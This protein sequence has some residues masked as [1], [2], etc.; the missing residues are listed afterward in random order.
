[1]AARA[2]PSSRTRRDVDP[3]PVE[4]L[5]HHLGERR[6]AE[7]AVEVAEGEQV[8]ELGPV[9]VSP[10]RQLEPLAPRE[11]GEQVAVGGLGDVEH[12]VGLDHVLPGGRESERGAGPGPDLGGRL[13]RSGC[14]AGRLGD[15][16]PQR[17]APLP[18]ALVQERQRRRR[19]CPI[20]PSGPVTGR[21][22][23]GGAPGLLLR[24]RPPARRR[25][26]RRARP[27]S[28][29]ARLP[30][31][32]DGLPV[33]R[34]GPWASKMAPSAGSAIEAGHVAEPLL[35]ERAGE[36]VHAFPNLLELLV[37]HG[38]HHRRLDTLRCG[39]T[40][41][42]SMPIYEYDCPKCGRFDVAPEDVGA[43]R[44]AGTTPAARR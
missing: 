13:P 23:V 21:G 44:S 5:E 16:A 27:A 36:R 19:R 34:R 32:G 8:E 17:A 40:F 25:A 3:E 37:V 6:R 33:R 30:Q 43:R 18:V 14:R 11:P 31:L 7:E 2:P 35:G 10:R 15:G 1:M 28:R 29:S 38:R 42:A 4:A 24:R 12:L 41:P 20:G 26:R 39:I 22:R 9:Q